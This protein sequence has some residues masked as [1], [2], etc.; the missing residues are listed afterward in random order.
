M[1]SSIIGSDNIGKAFAYVI[2]SDGSA[3]FVVYLNDSG[4]A[5]APNQIDI[6][7]GRLGPDL[8][9]SLDVPTHDG[10]GATVCLMA[11]PGV[12]PQRP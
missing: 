1:N 12:L 5:L 11:R 3:P 2:P 10:S 8:N 7:A 6:Y 4:G 9:T